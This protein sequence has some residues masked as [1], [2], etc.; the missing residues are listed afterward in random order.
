MTDIE[1]PF[2]EE[3]FVYKGTSWNVV[4][5]WDQWF[6]G[7]CIVYLTTRLTDDLMSLTP[8]EKTDLWE[9]IVPR[10]TQAQKKAFGCDRINYAH[11]ANTVKH[12]HWHIVPRYEV[13]PEREFDGEKFIDTQVG[14]HYAHNPDKFLPPEK[15][16]RIAEELRKYF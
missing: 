2:K 1:L 12:V 9:D 10:L 6:L 7:R 15:L 16:N 3:Y 4:V 8:K 14:H 13:N 5:A 11:L